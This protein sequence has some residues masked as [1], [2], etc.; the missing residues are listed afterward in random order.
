MSVSC[1]LRRCASVAVGQRRRKDT[2]GGGVLPNLG[3]W[4]R[5]GGFNTTLTAC[6]SFCLQPLGG[7]YHPAIFPS[8]VRFG[9]ASHS[10]TP[11]W[12]YWG[13]YRQTGSWYQRS[14]LYLLYILSFLRVSAFII[15]SSVGVSGWLARGALPNGNAPRI[16]P[17]LSIFGAVVCVVSRSCGSRAGWRGGRYL[18]E[19]PPASS[20]PFFSRCSVVCSSLW[21]VAAAGSSSWWLLRK[22]PATTASR[23]CSARLHRRFFRSSGGGSGWLAR[24]ALPNGN[25]PRIQPA[26]S[27]FGAAVC[28]VSRS[29]GKI[30]DFLVAPL[31]GAMLEARMPPI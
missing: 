11:P 14:T 18:T 4:G 3:G 20:Q 29:C 2:N 19:T 23:L 27:I 13:N 8:G 24:G 22:P 28:G 1:R 25:A 30:G 31:R 7:S 16:Q 17:A 6:F 15:C 12:G 26:L 10:E 5:S 9:S 21:R